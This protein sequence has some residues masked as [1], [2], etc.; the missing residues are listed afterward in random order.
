MS[1]KKTSKVKE[2]FKG[3]KGE[4]KKIVWPSFSS[5]A[6]NTAVVVVF[7]III[8]ALIWVLDMLFGGLFNW[9]ISIGK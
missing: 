4:F 9:V 5:V 7:C 3:V 6:K 1:E 8:G 2:F